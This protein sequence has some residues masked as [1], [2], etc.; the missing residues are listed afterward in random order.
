[1]AGS[2]GGSGMAISGS[3]MRKGKTVKDVMQPD[4]KATKKYAQRKKGY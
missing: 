4:K 3:K 1:M 2:M